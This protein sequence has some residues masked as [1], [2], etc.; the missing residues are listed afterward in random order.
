MRR[1]IRI[2][3]ARGNAE[4]AWD[5]EKELLML[6][7]RHPNDARTAPIFWE[8]ANGRKALLERYRAGEF[9]PEIVLG[10]YYSEWVGDHLSGWQRT[11]CD[12]G[13][14]RTV[15]RALRI[16][17]TAF[18]QE[19]SE[20]VL[21]LARWIDSPCAR[22]EAVA[23]ETRSKQRAKKDMKQHLLAMSDYAGCT[24]IKY[25]YAAGADASPEELSQLSSDR[26]AAAEEFAARTAI[27]EE[28]F[29]PMRTADHCLEK[30]FP[31]YAR[32]IPIADLA[33]VHTR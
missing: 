6:I 17:A 16:E 8:I 33:C 30:T 9:P 23:G 1:S 21:R 7:R 3:R 29:G 27:Y 4:A 28:R 18:Y 15:L 26:H 14:R 10:C 19:A 31:R 32:T 11:G 20:I 2:E 5:E 24:Q 13:N 22:P 12:S 25:E